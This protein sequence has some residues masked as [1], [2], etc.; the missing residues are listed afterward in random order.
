MQ[1][2]TSAFVR[3]P[4]NSREAAPEATVVRT[5]TASR[6]I[7]LVDEAK[8]IGIVL[9]V[10]GHASGI[11]PVAATLIYAMHMPL[12]FFLSG[13]LLS[14]ERVA[15][16]LAEH[17]RRLM[18]DLLGPYVIFFAGSFAY[19]LLSLRWGGRAEKFSGVSWF[20]PLLGFAS[21]LADRLIV[22][23]ALWFLPC[24][25]T[26]MLLYLALRK[27]VGPRATMAI[28]L[29]AGLICMVY[30]P[31]ADMRLPWGL[32]IA[33]VAMIFL[34]AGSLLRDA[35]VNM[36][37]GSRVVRA[38]ALPL[39]LLTFVALA[40]H[41]GRVD[42][43]AAHFGPSP[44]LYLACAILGIAFVL[45]LASLSRA[46]RG[47][48]S[49]LAFNSLIIFGTHPVT[50]NFSAGVARLG[51]GASD[52]FLHSTTWLVLSSLIGIAAAAPIGFALRRLLPQIFA[53]HP[54]PRVAQPASTS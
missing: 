10:V 17:V 44:L 6:R 3:S 34:A 47:L 38:T 52:H 37:P 22:N 29:T 11:T 18:R 46:A 50:M 32:D 2:G 54:A 42:L 49:W 9:V 21:G 13:Y 36:A 1:S 19:W 35:G 4:S 20:D 14:A 30:L 28:A 27:W 26:T 45:Q 31:A 25:F 40:L 12:F 5:S 39:L 48:T 43:N 16:P 8:A 23:P 24:L 53:R 51:F 7:A 41:M 15:R 33:W